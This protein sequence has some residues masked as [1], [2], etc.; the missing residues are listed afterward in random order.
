MTFV[1]CWLIFP[2][3]LMAMAVGCG[4]LVERIADARLPG[5]LLPAVGLAVFAVVG[6]LTTLTDSTAELTA[7]ALLS[8]AFAGFMISWPLR[9]R[10]LDGWA[11]GVAI[12][13]YVVY[14]AP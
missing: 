5:P 8:L 4:L 7:P 14:G 3:L 2:L 9:D 12:G 10:H 11:I 1:V 6:Q 13:A